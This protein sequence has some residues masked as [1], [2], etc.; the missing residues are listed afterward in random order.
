M[1]TL[2][3]LIAMWKRNRRGREERNREFYPEY[4]PRDVKPLS[5]AE[6]DDV[7]VKHLGHVARSLHRG[8]GDILL[9]P[10]SF[11]GLSNVDW[12]QSCYIL[13]Q[14]SQRFQNWQTIMLAGRKF[15][16]DY[17]DMDHNELSAN[18]IVDLLRKDLEE[19]FYGEDEMVIAICVNGMLAMRDDELRNDS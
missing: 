5:I 11:G 2:A 9:D 19:K 16:E 14:V 4:V 10:D 1:G 7:I 3:G 18:G 13:I 17:P 6:I 12:W 8:F 15:L